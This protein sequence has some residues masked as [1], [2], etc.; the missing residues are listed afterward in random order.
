MKVM[1][2]A[3]RGGQSRAL[4]LSLLLNAGYMLVEFVSGLAFNSLALM[5]DAAH[6][7]SDV[8]GLALALLAARLVA[9]RATARHTFGFERAEVLGAQ[10]NGLLILG[11][12]A[13]IVWEALQRL[14]GGVGEVEG[15][16]LLLVA[17]VGL[18]V[19]LGSAVLLHRAEGESLNMRGAFLHMLLDGAGSV[20]AVLAGVAVLGFGATWADPAISIGIAALV[21]LPA[22]WLIRDATNVL[23]EGTPRG[24]D[25]DAV[26]AVLMRHPTVEEV[27]HLHVWNLAS[28]TKA[29]SAHLVLR[30]ALD[31]HAA[32]RVVQTVK[33]SIADELGMTHVTLEAECHGCGDE[34]EVLGIVT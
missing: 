8:A 9:R 32:E 25:L 27:H 18:G 28:D 5:A 30:G 33:D 20:G 22:W 34:H 29:L 7:L 13:W 15:L 31:L 24:V 1:D 19:N 10:L 16:R 6:M 23:L 26:R 11:T 4:K 21:L 2:A 14:R 12:A 3:V 17:A